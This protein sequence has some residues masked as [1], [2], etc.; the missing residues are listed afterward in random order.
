MQGT[1]ARPMKNKPDAS[2]RDAEAQRK[3][4]IWPHF[5]RET[6]YPLIGFGVDRRSRTKIKI[7]TASLRLCARTSFQIL[8]F[9][10]EGAQTKSDVSRYSP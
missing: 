4:I 5:V 3:Q 1:N 6:N 9:L 2:R 7:L 8:I 10:R